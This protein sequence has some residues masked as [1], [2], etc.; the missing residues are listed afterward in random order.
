[1]SISLPAPERRLATI[2]CVIPGLSMF[3]IGLYF[4]QTL[5]AGVDIVMLQSGLIG[6]LGLLGLTHQAATLQ[7]KRLDASPTKSRSQSSPS[8]ERRL[9]RHVSARRIHSRHLSLVKCR[10][11]RANSVGN[12]ATAVRT[13]VDL[14]TH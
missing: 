10:K 14:A 11:G 13:D 7:I 1:M 5:S 3:L 8:V 12:V 2:H 4:G 6:L 9:D